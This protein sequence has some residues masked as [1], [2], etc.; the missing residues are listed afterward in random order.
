MS[1]SRS[2][3]CW[4][5]LGDMVWKRCPYFSFLFIFFHTREM[6]TRITTKMMER[7]ATTAAVDLSVN[8]NSFIHLYS[9]HV[10]GT[11]SYDLQFGFGHCNWTQRSG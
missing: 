6:A 4:L 10:P 11:R 2:V 3:S 8:T 5:L 7:D 9:Q 1:V